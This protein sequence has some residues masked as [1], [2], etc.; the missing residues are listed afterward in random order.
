MKTVKQIQTDIHDIRC[1]VIENSK[2]DDRKS[3]AAVKKLR[4]QL[5]ILATCL[6]YLESDPKE[7]FVK[8]EIERIKTKIDLRMRE[9][10]FD[11]KLDMGTVAKLKRE[12]RKKYGIAHL[13]DQLKTLRY[14][15]K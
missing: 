13:E 7:Q 8:A 5:P 14:L 4:K 6:K 11:E 15:L 9:F 3:K 12:H 10:T 2:F 1:Q